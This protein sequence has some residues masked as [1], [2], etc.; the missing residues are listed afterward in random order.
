MRPVPFVRRAALVSAL[1]YASLA[2]TATA[3][4]THAGPGDAVAGPA[5]ASDAAGAVERARKLVS[6]G[7]LAGAAR[8]LGVYVA[9]HPTELEPARYFGD[10]TYRQGDAAGAERTYRAILRVAPGDRETHNRLGGIYAAQDRVAEAIAEFAK[11]LPLGTAYGHLVDLHRRLGDLAAFEVPFRRAADDLPTSAAAQYGLGAVYRAEHRPLLAVTYLERALRLAPRA[12]ATLAE[13]G[14]A[15]LDLDRVG[16]AIGTFQRCLAIEPDN[17]AALVNLADAYIVQERYPLAHEALE[18]AVGVR[19]DG[20]EALID[21][22]YLED[23]AGHWQTAVAHYLHAIAVDPL[24]RDAYV[25]LGF[26]YD[27]HQ[28]FALAEAAFL[29]GLSVAPGDGRLHYL[30]G[31]TYRQQGK[32]E[33]ALREYRRAVASDE[34]DVARAASRDLR[35]FVET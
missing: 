12:C 6:G 19:P 3:Q 33:L 8:G 1:V 4:V 14:S 18:R 22:G 34:P 29:K 35:S 2:T 24:A 30:L 7:D 21:T 16:E 5:F 23:V 17:Y 13:L 27:S 31:A 28:L 10:L 11:S 26:D 20:A 9:A 25:D 32:R 15:Y